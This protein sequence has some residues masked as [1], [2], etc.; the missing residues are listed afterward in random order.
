MKV[1]YIALH[2]LLKEN[3]EAS[4]KMQGQDSNSTPPHSV[5][6]TIPLHQAL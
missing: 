4:S 5:L 6:L 3:N 1:N 2:E